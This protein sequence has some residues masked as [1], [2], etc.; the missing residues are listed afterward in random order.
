MGLQRT[1]CSSNTVHKSET[2]LGKEVS[3]REKGRYLQLHQ[4]TTTLSP[5]KKGGAMFAKIIRRRLLNSPNY[6]TYFVDRGIVSKHVA[7]D[8]KSL[9]LGESLPFPS[10]IHL[11]PGARGKEKW[12]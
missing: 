10:F 3:R 4:K 2:P 9:A 11:S 1:V 7:S 6:F 5:D 8:G 12:Q